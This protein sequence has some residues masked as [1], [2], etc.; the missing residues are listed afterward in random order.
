[1]A[2]N[3]YNIS[4]KVQTPQPKL[5]DIVLTLDG[6]SAR[7]LQKVLGSIGGSGEGRTVVDKIYVA[8]GSAGVV[9]DSSVHFSGSISG[10]TRE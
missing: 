3:N 1:M 6:Q 8:L 4:A 5:P 2:S 9:G 10:G 7:V